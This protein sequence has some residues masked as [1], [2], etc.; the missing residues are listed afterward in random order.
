MAWCGICGTGEILSWKREHFSSFWR[1]SSRVL[2]VSVSV[3]PEP[4]LQYAFYFRPSKTK[5][6]WCF[7]VPSGSLCVVGMQREAQVSA[8]PTRLHRVLTEVVSSVKY[9]YC[10]GGNSLDWEV[11]L[12]GRVLASHV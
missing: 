9:W 8:G 6:L 7:T 5:L 10:L 11:Q 1:V 2:T 4:V 12:S 3:M